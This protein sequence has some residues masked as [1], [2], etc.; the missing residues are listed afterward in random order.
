MGGTIGT[1]ADDIIKEIEEGNNAMSLV[2]EIQKRGP[3]F[4]QEVA[5]AMQNF[6]LMN[7]QGARNAV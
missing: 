2:T 7:T 3:A 5:K 1:E 4:E 6:D